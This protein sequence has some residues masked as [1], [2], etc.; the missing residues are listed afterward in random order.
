MAG[1][2]LGLIGSFA[3]AAAAGAY[4]SIATST[5]SGTNTITF[6]SIPSTYKHLQVRFLVN[7]ADQGSLRLRLNGDSSTSSY[8]QHQLEGTGTVAQA[9]GNASGSVSGIFVVT[10]ND[11]TSI[12][13]VGV[14]DIHDYSSTSKNKTVRL[15]S[16]YDRNGA[17]R[18]GLNSGLYLST[19]AIDSLTLY[20][21]GANFTSGSTF[22]LYGI[23]GS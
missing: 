11:T 13:S 16:G 7:Q 18:I 9:S 19:S 21:A 6:S 2:Q 3:A 17:G 10:C 1:I 20:V 5:P 4:E 15:F 12:F 23:K 8:A 14:I 22:S